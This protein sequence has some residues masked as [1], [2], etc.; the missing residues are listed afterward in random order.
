MAASSVLSR[1]LIW[2]RFA[3]GVAI[4]LVT[5][6][7]TAFSAHAPW[8]SMLPPVVAGF[9]CKY[10]GVPSEEVTK[11]A[12]QL[13]EPAKAVTVAVSALQ[14]LPPE[15]A[16]QATSQLMASLPPEARQRAS[17]TPPAAEPPQTIK[18]VGAT[19][20]PPTSE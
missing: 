1:K 20:P 8:L 16:E 17:L 14:S 5:G 15:K 10:L 3:G 7:A 19:E 2:Q 18:F 12:L 9:I 11:L 6:I 4:L 13:M